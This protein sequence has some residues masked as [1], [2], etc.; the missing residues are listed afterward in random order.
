MSITGWTLFGLIVGSD[1]SALDPQPSK[2]G[3]AS[4]IILGIVGALAGGFLG[5]MLLGV[6]IT[7]FSMPSSLVAIGG[8]LI[9]LFI[10]RVLSSR[11]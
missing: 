1:A 9:L 3:L 7:G 4:S 11:T 5:S 10:G 8:S 6:T 2:G